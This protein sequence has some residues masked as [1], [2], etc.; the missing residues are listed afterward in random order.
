[1]DNILITVSW[2][3][4][5]GEVDIELPPDIPFDQ[6]APIIVDALGWTTAGASTPYEIWDVVSGRQL[7]PSMALGQGGIWD[8]AR[9][10]FQDSSSAV[11]SVTGHGISQTPIVQK[12]S[13]YKILKSGK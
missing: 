2:K 5:Y 1:M 12:P 4:R 11:P 8:G 13:P 9:L 7:D 10:A 3:N 6:L